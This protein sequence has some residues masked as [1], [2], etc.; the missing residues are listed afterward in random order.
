MKVPVWHLRELK[1]GN[2][3]VG[4]SVCVSPIAEELEHSQNGHH[5]VPSPS[6]LPMVDFERIAEKNPTHKNL[7][8]LQDHTTDDFRFLWRQIILR[9]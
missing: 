5:F 9:I 8:R 6:D 7:E 2:A 4:A 3:L 1:F